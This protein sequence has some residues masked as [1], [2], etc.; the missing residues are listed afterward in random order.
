MHGVTATP[1]L[2]AIACLVPVS[3]WWFMQ[4]VGLP[5]PAINNA[6]LQAVQAIL[7]LQFLCAGLFSPQWTT[8]SSGRISSGLNI[9]GACGSVGAFVDSDVVA[10][11]NR[12]G[13][14]GRRDGP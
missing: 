7:L 4:I 14:A 10:G 1:G 8:E 3:S 9:V 6:S 5:G 13:V 2:V 11:G 12:Y